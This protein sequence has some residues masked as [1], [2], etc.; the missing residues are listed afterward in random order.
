MN[1]GRVVGAALLVAGALAA[2]LG[3][4]WPAVVAL[5][6]GFLFATRQVEGVPFVAAALLTAAGLVLAAARAGLTPGDLGLALDSLL[7]GLLWSVGLVLLVGV[8]VAVALRVPRLRRSFHDPRH[9]GPGTWAA[10]RALLDVP[11]GTVLLEE[12]AFRGVVLALLVRELGTPWAVVVSSVLFGLW[13]ILGAWDTRSG[14]PGTVAATTGAGIAFAVLRVGTGS[15]L[16]PAAL[17]WAL[18][19]LGTAAGWHVTRGAAPGDV[20]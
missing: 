3:W 9:R 16:P 10:R 13:H 11:L 14:I 20:R 12:L 18:N 6:V 15:L 7:P 5:L 17:H 4:T 2:A 1:R 19:G 8:A